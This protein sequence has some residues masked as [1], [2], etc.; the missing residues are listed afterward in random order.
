M[1]CYDLRFPELAR[2]LVAAG[3]EVLVVPAAW[4][5]GPRKVDHWTTLARARAI[6]NTAYVVAVGQPGPRYTGHSIVVDPLGDVL[7]EAGEKAETLQVTLEPRGRRPGAPDQPL[8]GQPTPL[9]RRPG[10]LPARVDHRPPPSR[11]ATV[12]SKPAA[13]AAAGFGRD[14]CGRVLL[15]RAGW[16]ALAS[17]RRPTHR[18]TPARVVR[19]RSRWRSRPDWWRARA[20]A[21]SSTAASR[22]CSGLAVVVTDE[23]VLRTGAA[24]LTCVVTAVFAVMVTVPA[25]TV[26]QAAR[27]VVVA[28]LVAVVGA[29]AVVGLEPTLS[30]ARFAYTTLA[31]SLALCRVVV[32]RL[33]AGLHGLGRRGLVVVLI[34]GAVLAATLAYAEVLRRYGAPDLVDAL[35]DGR[36][37]AWTRCTAP[38]GPCRPWWAS[39]PSCGAR[40]CEPG[41]GRAGGSAPS[42]SPRPRRSPTPSSTRR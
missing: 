5:A 17:A 1:T 10:T 42:A 31:A 21:P 19:S 36:R 25:V 30:L 35:L 41:V 7:A 3:A 34:G 16:R 39:P 18:R 20:A 23:P 9:S 2:A 11:R 29:A 40:T 22:C 13:S 8:P 4:V 33:G 6:E 24:V 28:M 26:S 38:L 27:E 14:R 15:R 37:W 32:Y 12:A